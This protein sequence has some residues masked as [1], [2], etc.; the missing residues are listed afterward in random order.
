MNH[1]AANGCVFCT[2]AENPTPLFET[3]TLYAM[4]DKFPLVPGHTLIV[5]KE[6]LACYGAA[7]PETLRELD[8]AAATVRRFLRAAYGLPVVT[9]ENGVSGQS[10]FHAHLHLIPLPSDAVPPAVAE[11]AEVAP[12]RGWDDVRGHYVQHR[13]YRYLEVAER[14]HLVPGYSPALGPFTG[15]LATVT[16]LEYG[17]RG[18]IKNTTP[19]DVREVR[20]RWQ[21]WQGT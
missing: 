18:W 5:S 2:R 14:R 10:V 7:D 15:W 4:P 1:P 17:S 6:H 3:P 19:D 21:D 20:R 11:H 8:D 9:W 12:I 16:G 13:C